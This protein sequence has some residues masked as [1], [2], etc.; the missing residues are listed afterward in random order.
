[1]KYC[2]NFIT[3]FVYAIVGFLAAFIILYLFTQKFN[4]IAS[5]VAGVINF[6]ISGYYARFICKLNGK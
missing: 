1:M 5:V 2:Y 4:L 6:A 3:Q